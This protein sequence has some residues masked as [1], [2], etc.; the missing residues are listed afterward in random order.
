MLAEDFSPGNEWPGV[1]DVDV[2]SDVNECEG[3]DV[4]ARVNA[5][6]SAG[7]VIVISVL[8]GNECP[9]DIANFV[10]EKSFMP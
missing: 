7:V 1:A 8:L 2:V 4:D 10:I 3:V 6:A 5:V 9:V